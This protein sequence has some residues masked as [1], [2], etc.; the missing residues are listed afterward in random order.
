M[1]GDYATYFTLL[2]MTFIKHIIGLFTGA[3]CGYAIANLIMLYT[4]VIVR[5]SW[6]LMLFHQPTS[7]LP[8]T[9]WPEVLLVLSSHVLLSSVAYF[10]L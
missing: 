2:H 10:C 9:S 1:G 4:P 8:C 5:C 6:Y 3:Y 7:I